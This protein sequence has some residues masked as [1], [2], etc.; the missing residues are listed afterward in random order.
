MFQIHKLERKPRRL[1]SSR[2]QF[3]H[4]LTVMI[5]FIRFRYLAQINRDLLLTGNWNETS[6]IGREQTRLYWAPI[7]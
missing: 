4:H 1:R 5:P 2:E 7:R 6:K 3:L